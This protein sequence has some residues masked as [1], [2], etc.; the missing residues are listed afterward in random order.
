MVS[1]TYMSR[2]PI[3]GPEGRARFNLAA[4]DRPPDE[5]GRLVLIKINNQIGWATKDNESISTVVLSRHECF[6][7]TLQIDAPMQI[8]NDGLIFV[9]NSFECLYDLRQQA[10]VDNVL[11]NQMPVFPAACRMEV[12]GDRQLK[13]SMPT[14]YVD[15]DKAITTPTGVYVK[16]KFTTTG[17]DGGL[18]LHDFLINPVDI[19]CVSPFWKPPGMEDPSYIDRHIMY[20]SFFFVSASADVVIQHVSIFK[21]FWSSSD[22]EKH[23]IGCK[24]KEL[25][26]V[27]RAV[28][29]KHMVQETIGGPIS[30]PCVDLYPMA[31]TGAPIPNGIPPELGWFTRDWI[32]GI[33]RYDAQ[34]KR[35]FQDMT[36]ILLVTTSSFNVCMARCTHIVSNVMLINGSMVEFTRQMKGTYNIARQAIQQDDK[37]SAWHANHIKE[38]LLECMHRMTIPKNG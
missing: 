23:N 8:P 13:W 1:I 3:F 14:V 28:I 20:A 11:Y 7:N 30:Q 36:N 17:M 38:L 6:G 21:R 37:N 9:G 10:T 34:D 22:K 4:L 15:T 32:Q 16:A 31:Y 12:S 5:H 25:M 33:K 35:E 29:H 26:R 19:L 24:Y 18:I 27:S 2:I